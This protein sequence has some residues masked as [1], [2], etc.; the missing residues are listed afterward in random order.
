MLFFSETPR[1]VYR[2][3]Q[4]DQARKIM[5]KVYGVPENHWA[6]QEELE[7]I[8]AKLAAEDTNQGYFKDFYHM[9]F[10]ER[11]GYRIALGVLLQMFQQLTGANYFFYYGAQ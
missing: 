5:S 7:E 10:A 8:R 11:M 3:G 6:I 9:F 1:F 2:K 4:T